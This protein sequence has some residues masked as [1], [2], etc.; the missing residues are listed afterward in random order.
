[1]KRVLTILIFAL[2][3]IS[4]RQKSFQEKIDDKRNDFSKQA[5]I[6]NA[7][8]LS[9]ENKIDSII[10][11]AD[12]NPLLAIQVIDSIIQYD[13]ILGTTKN[14]ELHFLKG[15]F[16]YQVDRFAKAIDEFSL[17][18]LMNAASQ[19]ILAAKAG[20]HLKLKE[21]DLAL[22]E[23]KQAADINYDYYWNIGNY[24]EIRG[25]KDSALINYQKLYNHDTT[26]YEFC[27]ERIKEL[28]HNESKP[29]TELVYRNR[30]RFIILMHGIN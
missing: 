1:M 11:L 28:K 6:N 30:E 15:D 4:W 5:E 7:K 14:S 27:G 20:A 26:V 18:E 19:K 8:V 2:L 21:Y 22:N 9:L 3:L 25:Q 29:L 23:L 12:T 10:K 13:T 17:A 24:Y 16:Y